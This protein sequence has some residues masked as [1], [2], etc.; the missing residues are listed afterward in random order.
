MSGLIRG[1]AGRVGIR[2]SGQSVAAPG[3][4]SSSRIIGVEQSDGALSRIRGAADRWRRSH[5]RRP[6]PAYFEKPVNGSFGKSAMPRRDTR[7]GTCVR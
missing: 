3:G 2:G 7:S 4:A 6:V 5:A 1:L